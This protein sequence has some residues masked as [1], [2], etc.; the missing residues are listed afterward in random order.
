MYKTYDKAIIKF[1]FHSRVYNIHSLQCTEYSV[2]TVLYWKHM[3]IEAHVNT[4][5][6]FDPDV[7][8][9]WSFVL[10]VFAFVLLFLTIFS[11]FQN[12][13]HQ[14]LCFL[15]NSMFFCFL[16]KFRY[17]PPFSI[18]R[19]TGDFRLW[20]WM[21]LDEFTNLSQKCVIAFV[22]VCILFVKQFYIVGFSFHA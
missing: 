20:S 11:V 17:L 4:A 5:N 18:S 2:L 16:P 22:S 7:Q 12:F 10:L 1:W 15:W 3:S 9:M 19:K 13:C 8:H 14:K 6:R 21:S